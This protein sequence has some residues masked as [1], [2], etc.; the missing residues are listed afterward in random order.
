MKVSQIFKPTW[1]KCFFSFLLVLL[2]VGLF[3]VLF[4]CALDLSTDSFC[5]IMV[6]AFFIV[7][8]PLAL[9]QISILEKS[10]FV[11]A[12]ILQILWSYVLACIIF[13]LVEMLFNLLMK[14]YRQSVGSIRVF[15]NSFSSKKEGEKED[16]KTRQEEKM[17]GWG[18]KDGEKKRQERE[19]E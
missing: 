15:P 19:G 14:L 3:G 1:G 6:F 7:A 9:L 12:I 18:E 4:G 8:F 16:E 11:P 10:S 2:S 17:I 5:R 13:F